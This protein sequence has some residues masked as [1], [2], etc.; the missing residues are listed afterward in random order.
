MSDRDLLRELCGA[1]GVSGGEEPVR[2]LIL[3]EI[4]PFA[5]RVEISP[6]GNVVAFKSGR[7][8]PK[9]KLMLCAH[10]D[11][12]GL[13]ATHVTNEGLIRFDPVGKIARRALPG[14]SVAAGGVPG[15]VGVKPVH[16]LKDGEK[17]KCVPLR[18]LY[19][20]IGARTRAEA[21]TAVKPGS[22]FAFEPFFRVSGGTAMGKALGGRAGCALLLGMM[23]NDLEYDT[24]F[25]F[26]VQGEAGSC[27]AK[28]A[29]F[30]VEPEAAVVV[31]AAEADDVP[32]TDRD[33]QACRLGAG[34]AISFMDRR[35]VYDGACYRLA[36]QAAAKAGVP[37]QARRAI[38]GENDAG[39]IHVSRGGIRTAA[40]SLACRYPRL[41]IAE[42]CRE[43][44]LSAQKLIP[45]LA[46]MIEEERN[47]EQ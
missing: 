27:G 13:I 12:T 3:R 41:P 43:D 2:S 28:T 21:E 34:P 45:R 26:T 38:G 10:M 22:L 7:R 23:R 19:I 47:T 15:V 32:G 40:V 14:V 18:E 30:S 17:E 39:V 44:Y 20:D 5:D 24:I 33:R 29:A 11:E 1:Q 31:G 36:F 16:L 46:E 35:T 42:I 25:A 4:G 37:C 6:L 8:R 9:T